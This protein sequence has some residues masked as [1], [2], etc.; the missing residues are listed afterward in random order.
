MIKKIGQNF[1]IDEKIAIREV[2]YADINN[3]DVVLEIGPGR[4]ILTNIIASKAK[5]VIAIELDTSLYNFL[6]KNCP[7]NVHLINDDILKIELDNLPKFNKIVSNLPFQISSPFTFKIIEYNFSIGI[8]I[9]QK[10]FAQRLVAKTGSKHYSRISVN[11]YFKANCEYL[12][13]VRKDC[14]SPQPKVDS[15]IIKINPRKKQP[16]NVYNEEFYFDLVRNLFNHRR[17]KIKTT[18][19]EIYDKELQ[20]LPYQNN[21]VEDLAPEQIGKLSNHLFKLINA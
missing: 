11:V 10:E 15:A 18:I 2:D 16:F 20:S 9:Y 14:F 13:T 4:G 1:L 6:K 3:D 7:D 21:R 17:K 5:E 8:F 12:E 19:K